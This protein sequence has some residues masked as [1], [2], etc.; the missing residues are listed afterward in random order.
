VA[1]ARMFG[2]SETVIGLTVVAVGT[3]LPELATSVVAALKGESD[4]A[5]GNVVGSN[6][7]NLLGIL[8][9]TGLVQPIALPPGAGLDLLVMVAVAVLALP[10]SRTGL[11]LHRWEGAVLVGLYVVYT[12]WLLMR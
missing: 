5:L 7:F 10:I 3:S 6:V 12:A 1:L 2:L 9:I 8:G 4:L 11:R